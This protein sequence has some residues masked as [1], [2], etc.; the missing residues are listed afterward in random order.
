MAFEN[1]RLV[2]VVLRASSGSDQQVQTFHYSAI[3]ASFPSHD[4]DM[5]EL[6]D[7]IRDD[8]RTYQRARYT[9]AWTI[10]PVLVVEEIDPLNPTATRASWTSGSAV[11]GTK[12]LSSQLLPTG[13]CPLVALKSDSLGRRYNGRVFLGGSWAEGDNLNGNVESDWVG[14]ISAEFD[15]VPKQPDLATG[16]SLANCH[17]VIYSRTA[18]AANQTPYTADVT[19]FVVRSP[20]HYLRNR[21]PYS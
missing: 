9:N 15:N 5:Q 19:S 14:F 3:D 20:F 17:W 1:G 7:R 18:R 21:A 12:S 10:D 13:L 11:A 4:N 8:V 6:A 2:R 16:V